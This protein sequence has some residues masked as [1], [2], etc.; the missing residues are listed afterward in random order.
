MVDER[1]NRWKNHS[2]EQWQKDL[3]SAI[4]YGQ[5]ISVLEDIKKHCDCP[6]IDQKINELKQRVESIRTKYKHER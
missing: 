3:L 4:I 5:I 2:V 6:Y 1:E